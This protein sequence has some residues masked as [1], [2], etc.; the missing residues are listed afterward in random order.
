M[1]LTTIEMLIMTY[2][3]MLVTIISII[4]MVVKVLSAFKALRKDVADKTEMEA[5]KDQMKVVLHENYELKASI[6][7]LVE[8]IDKVKKE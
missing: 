5:V 3:P 6:K 7:E 8:K 1:D 2:A 4:A